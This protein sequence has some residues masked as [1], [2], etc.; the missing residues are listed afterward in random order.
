MNQEQQ[1]VCITSC[2]ILDKSQLQLCS[3]ECL[4]PYWTICLNWK[5]S[6]L[7]LSIKLL[8]AVNKFSLSEF[9]EKKGGNS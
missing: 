3:L 5:N 8:R 7:L 9:K 1:I 2:P 4:F 6:N